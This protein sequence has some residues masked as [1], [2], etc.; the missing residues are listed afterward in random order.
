[1][2]TSTANRLAQQKRLVARVQRGAKL[3]DR[4]APGWAAKIRPE[5]LNMARAGRC[6]LGQTFDDYFSGLLELGIAAADGGRYGFN[7]GGRDWDHGHSILAE[8]WIAQAAQRMNAA[9]EAQG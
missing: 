1:M 4:K 7:I 8:E 2:T 3:L 5:T 6:V 9:Q